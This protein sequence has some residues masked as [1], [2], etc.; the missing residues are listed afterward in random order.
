LSPLNKQQLNQIRDE[1]TEQIKQ[2]ALKIFARRGYA[3]TKTS[4]I[5]T[6]AGISEGLIFRYFKSKEELFTTLV[7][8]L[9]EEAVHETGNI[10]YLPGS[11]LEQ[12]RTLTRSMLDESGKYAFMLIQRARKADDI[13]EEAARILERHSIHALLNGLL[14]IF[15]KGQQTGQFSEGDP[16]KLLAW[17]LYIVNSLIMEE[18]AQEAYGM[19]SVDYLMRLLAK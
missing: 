17:Y 4:M 5:A 19:P 13:P 10:Q 6:E 3:G 7:R 2:A 16:E 11:P 12:I 14:P 1:R 9:M 8:E 15:V 18:V